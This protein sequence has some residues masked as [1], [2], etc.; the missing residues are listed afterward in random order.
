MMWTVLLSMH[1]VGLVGYTILLRKSA[2]ST[3]NKYALAAIMQTVI[4]MPAI[5]FL[6]FS[7]VRFNFTAPEWIGLVASGFML[8][9]LHLTAI[10]ALTQ[11]EASVF[12]I[13]YNLRLFVTTILGYLFLNELPKKLQIIGGLTIFISILMLNL[14]KDKKYKSAPILYGLLATVWFSFHA[15]LEKHNVTTV[16][17]E[18]YMLVSGSIAA[19]LL[20]IIVV[21]KG[22]TYK[23][24]RKHIDKSFVALMIFR[25]LSAWAYTYA[26]LY[27]SLAVVNYVSG[28]SVALIVMFGIIFL[29][30]REQI[31]QKIAAVAVALIGLT[32]ILISKL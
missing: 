5:L 25:P 16:G 15:V 8:V 29:G 27:G 18:S 23:H 19:S 12:T 22:V 17:F 3:I 4:F 11:L 10:K 14:H 20:W 30:E 31:K 28:L 32:L 21:M 24:I 7:D 26:L 1:L 6:F 2:L 9:G 13:L